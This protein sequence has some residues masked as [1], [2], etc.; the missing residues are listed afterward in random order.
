MLRK[1]KRITESRGEKRRGYRFQGGEFCANPDLISHERGKE[2]ETRDQRDKHRGGWRGFLPP[3]GSRLGPTL[4][5]PS[6]W[7]LIVSSYLSLSL[8]FYRG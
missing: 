6:V 7:W 2:R 3:R 4:Q 5:R 1:Y 8:Y